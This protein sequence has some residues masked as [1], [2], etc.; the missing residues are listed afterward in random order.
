M[1][2]KKSTKHQQQQ[3]QHAYQKG[4]PLSKKEIDDQ[5]RRTI[6]VGDEIFTYCYEDDKAACAY[7]GLVSYLCHFCFPIGI[8]SSNTNFEYEFLLFINLP[9]SFS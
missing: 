5:A 8:P 6:T 2:D 3:Q 1:I 4:P 9:S 7:C